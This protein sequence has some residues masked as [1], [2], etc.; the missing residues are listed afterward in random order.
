[1]NDKH[2]LGDLS[3]A[4]SNIDR[5]VRKAILYLNNFGYATF[6]SCEGH[7]ND[8]LPRFGILYDDFKKVK[9]FIEY[10]EN[11]NFNIWYEVSNRWIDDYYKDSEIDYSDQ[12]N[13][14]YVNSNLNVN[15][16][17]LYFITVK[18][19]NLDDLYSVVDILIKNDQLL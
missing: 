17:K 19:K 8:G 3:K 7:D 16:S 6:T 11:L 14:S 1:M 9:N 12:E 15:Y 5:K 10:L 13:I 18:F 2:N 4:L